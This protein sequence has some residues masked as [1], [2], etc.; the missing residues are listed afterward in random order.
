MPRAAESVS[1]GDGK[2]ATHFPKVPQVVD[3]SMN[4]RW[5]LP[6]GIDEILPDEARRFE[7][8]RRRLLDLLETWG[9][10]LVMPPLIEFLEALL[11]G[12][13]KDL[14]LQTFKLT[15]QLTGRLMGVRADMTPQA[16][17]IDA[18]Y[19]RRDVPVR[20]CYLGSVLRTRPGAFSDS[21]EP[22]QLGAEL[23]GHA[24]HDSDAEIVR[25]A[26]ATLKAAGV[27]PVFVALGHVGPF[28]ALVRRAGLNREQEDELFEALQR[29]SHPEVAAR[30]QEWS[31]APAVQQQIRALVDLHGQAGEVIARARSAFGDDSELHQVLDDLAAVGRRL[32]LAPEYLYI[33][34]AELQG[35]AYYTGFM[36]SGFVAGLGHAIVNGGRYDDVGRAFGRARPAVGFSIDLRRLIRHMPPEPV[37]RAAIYAPGI[38]DE[39]LAVLVAQL[40]AQGE[41]VIAGLPG[42]DATPSAL[43]CTRA[44][45]RDGSQ[46]IITTC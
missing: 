8:L 42:S 5:L 25:L 34:L 13:G 10:E 26:L 9:Y 31:V 23:F 21:R 2:S 6:E 12:V 14:D 11:T 18:H 27:E 24:G 33:D 32:T 38:E 36:F 28:R 17:R 20:L 37:A 30:L 44:L 39:S 41:Q 22:L 45:V 40:R 43:G 4:E 46:W 29:K 19:L 3:M 16:A 7:Q 15:D 35:Y 1:G